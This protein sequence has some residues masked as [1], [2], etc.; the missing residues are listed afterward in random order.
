MLQD[1]ENVELVGVFLDNGL[2][3]HGIVDTCA[4]VVYVVVCGRGAI[5]IHDYTHAHIRTHAH[6]APHHSTITTTAP[7]CQNMLALTTTALTHS[8]S[9]HKEIGTG[10][11]TG[12][13]DHSAQSATEQRQAMAMQS[14]GAP[15]TLHSMANRTRPL[16]CS[17]FL[18]LL[19]HLR[20][21]LL[22]PLAIAHV[23]LLVSLALL[24]GTR[25]RGITPLALP[26]SRGIL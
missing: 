9:C 20:L 23:P 17:P 6:T 15:F 5:L 13:K 14:R 16:T 4:V 26:R 18:D 10:V 12:P 19:Y 1:L 2:V 3:E 8:A 21:A 7:Q 24:G 11:V 25:A 22:V